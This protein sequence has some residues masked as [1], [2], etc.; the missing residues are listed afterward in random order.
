MSRYLHKINTNIPKDIIDWID[1]N[2]PKYKGL[3][4][5]SKKDKVLKSKEPDNVNFH[6]DPFHNVIDII[7]NE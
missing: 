3:C 1:I 6:F 5:Y 7:N 4:F 2:Y